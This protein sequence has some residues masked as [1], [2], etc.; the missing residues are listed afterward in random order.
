MKKIKAITVLMSVMILCGCAGA[1]NDP[2]SGVSDG[3]AWGIQ[4]KTSGTEVAATQEEL[5]EELQYAEGTVLRMATGYNSPQTGMSFDEETAKGGVT[6]ADGNT[7]YPGD[8]KPTWAEVE[9]RLNISIEDK[10]Q[11]NSSDNELAY[12]KGRFDEIDLIVGNSSSLTA[13]GETGQLLDLSRYMDLMPNFR[14]KLDEYPVARLSVT[15]NTD[16]GAI[17][18]APY[19]DGVDDIE[20]MPLMRVDWVQKLLDGAEPFTA[21]SCGSTGSF[22]YNPY[23]PTTGKIEVEVVRPDGK[24]RVKIFKDYDAFGNIIEKMN[25]VGTLNGVEAVNLLRQY[26]DETYDGYYGEKRSELFVGQDAAWDVDEL[27]A[28]LRC[29]SANSRTL[30]GTKTVQGIFT[31]D[32]GDNQRRCDMW[33][34]AGLLFGVRGL[35]S[36]QEYLYL[37]SEGTLR[38]ARQEPETYRALERMHDIAREGLISDSFLNGEEMTSA[39]MLENDEGFMHYDYNQTQTIYNRTKLQSEDG[40]KYMGVLPPI[41]RWADGTDGGRYM[42]FTESWRGVKTIGWAISAAGVADDPDKL[43]AALKL[44]DYAYSNAGVVLMSYGPDTFIQTKEDGFYETFPFI[45]KRMPVMAED[46]YREM[47]EKADGNYTQYARRYLGSTLGFLK[48]QAF[49]YQCTEEVGKEGSSHIDRAI[50]LGVIRHPELSLTENPWYTL[51]PTVFPFTK[52]E[53]DLRNLFSNLN[54]AFSPSKGG[55]NIFVDIIVDGCEVVGSEGAEQCA[56]K[57]RT[58]MGGSDYMEIVQNA[59]NRLLAGYEAQ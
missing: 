25:A 2:S 7:Y 52:K 9:K 29:I 14:T 39:D 26:I 47:W 30:N 18:F 40:E 32:D 49:E 10:Y 28:L 35:D 36:R 17:Y 19:F 6:L 37:D 54:D 59:W 43:C 24:R 45:G 51:I 31:R 34:L 41:A 27:V 22:H 3:S 1:A 38:D 21:E 48:T 15:G 11:G 42:R 23:M 44:I 46:A 50:S 56:E 12:W 33:R 58:E 4:D 5:P 16:I 8:L 13:L 55:T 57:V 53:V 20:R